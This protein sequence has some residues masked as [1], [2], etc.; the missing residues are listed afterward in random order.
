LGS[1]DIYLCFRYALLA[2]ILELKTTQRVARSLLIY[3][4]KD[5]QVFIYKDVDAGCSA[6]K[7]HIKKIKIN[8]GRRSGVLFI[9]ADNYKT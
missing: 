3:D 4:K 1:I 2:D 5:K 7:L 8:S 9:Y 6:N